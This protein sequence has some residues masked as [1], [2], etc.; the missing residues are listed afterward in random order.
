MAKPETVD[1]YIAAQPRDLQSVLKQVRG[2]IRKALPRAE[3][4]ISYQIPAYKQDGRLVLYFAGW[5]EHYSLYPV[6]KG[7]AAAFKKDFARYEL[8]NKG[9]IRL[10]LDQK[11]PTGLIARVA[12]FRAQEVA[13]RTGVAA[14]SKRKSSGRPRAAAKRPAPSRR[15]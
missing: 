12:K 11:V 9:T 1:A 13:E 14:S 8:S 2:A 5:R 10:P 15:K 3:E 4:V 6:T 7:T